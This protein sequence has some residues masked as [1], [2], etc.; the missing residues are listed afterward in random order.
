VSDFP[1][2]PTVGPAGTGADVRLTFNPDQDYWPSWTA[3]GQGILYSFVSDTPGPQ[4]RCVG[5]LP[6]TGGTNIWQLCDNRATQADSVNSF[7]AYALAAD[8]QLLYTEAVSTSGPQ[9]AAPGESTLW[10]A[11]TAAP[12]QRRALLSLPTFVGGQ[13]VTWLADI[14]WTGPNAFIALAQD[15]SLVVHCK[16]CAILDSTFAGLAVVRGT[17]GPSGATM[18]AVPGTDGAS[19]YSMAENGASIVFTRFGEHVLYKIPAGGGTPVAVTTVTPAAEL[20]GVSCTAG[21]CVVADD[22][23]VTGCDG[24]PLFSPSVAVP[25]ELRAVTLATGSVQVLL[26]DT[27]TLVATPKIS[28]SGHDV[29]TQRGGLF[30]HVQ[31][32]SLSTADLHL[33]LGLV[34]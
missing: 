28:P 17:I 13:S 27:L 33:Y 34:P 7:T 8:G 2:P 15:F 21:V 18:T 9:S 29:V 10:L 20:L 19:S 11:D 4:H 26:A 30:G 5:L 32:I 3:D 23:V 22:P 12:F 24:C 6:A 16:G 1:P 31:T 25:A 14:D